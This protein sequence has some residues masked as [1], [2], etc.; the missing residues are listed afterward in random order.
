MTTPAD[1]QRDHRALCAQAALHLTDT[2]REQLFAIETRL[3]AGGHPVPVR[4]FRIY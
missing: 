3:A 4:S 1:L 2:I